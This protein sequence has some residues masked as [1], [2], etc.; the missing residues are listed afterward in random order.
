MNPKKIIESNDLNN[1]T[2]ELKAVKLDSSTTDDVTTSNVEFKKMKVDDLRK[3]ALS[4]NLSKSTEINKMKKVELVSLLETNKNNLN[5][6]NQPINVIEQLNVLEE[7]LQVSEVSATQPVEPE[8]SPV[9]EQAN[10]LEVL[11]MN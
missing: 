7:P 6:T 1:L 5:N 2:S 11:I 9:S 4:K 3:L 8:N 10:E